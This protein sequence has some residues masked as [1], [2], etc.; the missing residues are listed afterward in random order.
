MKCLNYNNLAKE[1]FCPN[2]GQKT[3]IIRFSFSHISGQD[4]HETKLKSEIDYLNPICIRQI[5]PVSK[6]YRI[7][8]Q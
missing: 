8:N 4:I 6:N 2:Y 7:L 3:S 5:K 1:N